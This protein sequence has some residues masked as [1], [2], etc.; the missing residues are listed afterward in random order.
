M[1]CSVRHRQRRRA[2]APDGARHLN[3]TI[4]L[5]SSSASWR[6]SAR[7]IAHVGDR[8]EAHGAVVR[9]QNRQRGEIL[10]GRG[11]RDGAHALLLVAD[12]R[13]AA[14]AARPAMR[15]SWCE[16]SP[17]V[18]P[19]A[20]SALGSRSTRISRSTPPTRL[21]DAHAFDG[22]QLAA[23]REIDEP[24]QLLFAHARGETP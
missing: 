23:H 4:G 17:A 10:H 13:L 20:L 19:S 18:V 7:L 3:P 5:P 1:A 15:F 8:I 16:M 6:C 22:A 14:R 21:I 2:L 9:Q 24:G 11:R 12:A